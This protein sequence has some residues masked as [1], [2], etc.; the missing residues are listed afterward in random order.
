MPW[1]IQLFVPGFIGIDLLIHFRSTAMWVFAACKWLTSY[2]GDKCCHVLYV[3]PSTTIRNGRAN[4]IA[5][6]SVIVL[7]VN[8]RRT[9]RVGLYRLIES[10]FPVISAVVVI[11]FVTELS[12][13]SCGSGKVCHLLKCPTMVAFPRDHR[14]RGVTHEGWTPTSRQQEGNLQAQYAKFR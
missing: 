9:E 10:T 7:H 1:G 8:G 11:L 3:L 2:H 5:C 4:D 12:C 13:S 6:L 14:P